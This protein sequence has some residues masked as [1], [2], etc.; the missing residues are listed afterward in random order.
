MTPE[1]AAAEQAA[2]AEAAKR[3]TA[4]LRYIVAKYG[5]MAGL[6][7]QVAA[8]MTKLTDAW[9]AAGGNASPAAGG[10]GSGGEYAPERSPGG[11]NGGGAYG[12]RS[13]PVS[14]GGLVQHHPGGSGGSSSMS[15]SGGGAG[16]SWS[17]NA[18]AGGGVAWGS[19]GGG[20]GG[21]GAGGGGAGGSYAPGGSGGGG[22]GL[23][24]GYTPGGL[25]VSSG[26][27]LTPG[28]DGF[29]DELPVVA[30]SV[31]GYRWWTIPAPDLDGSPAHADDEWDPGREARLRGAWADWQPGVN[32]AVCLANPDSHLLPVHDPELIP[33]LKCGCGYWAYWGAQRHELGRAAACRSSALSRRGAGPGSAR[34]ASALPRPGSWPSTCR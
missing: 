10:S 2:K 26:G 8:Q 5:H 19:A 6:T 33:A 34:S 11:S 23:V 29:S 24:P 15:G 9:Q 3:I 30:G 31:T 27:S 22:G 16:S 13:G 20:G 7:Q 12:S 21:G 18:S 4:G 32:H 14:A 17:P 28:A 1:E 25:V